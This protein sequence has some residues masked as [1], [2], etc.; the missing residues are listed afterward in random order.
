MYFPN[1]QLTM[2]ILTIAFDKTFVSLSVC[3]LINLF[4]VAPA[5]GQF[6]L[7]GLPSEI[8]SPLELTIQA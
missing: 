7:Q 5:Y 6:K 2:Y 1:V 4:L 3:G 8:I